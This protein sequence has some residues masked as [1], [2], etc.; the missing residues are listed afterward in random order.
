MSM[1]ERFTRGGVSNV[2]IAGNNA[3][4]I[5]AIGVTMVTCATLP[6]RLSGSYR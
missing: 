3:L 4:Q 6:K 2:D 1:A 5:T